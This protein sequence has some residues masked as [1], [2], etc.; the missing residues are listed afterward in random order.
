MIDLFSAPFKNVRKPYSSYLA[1]RARCYTMQTIMYVPTLGL[2]GKATHSAS[3]GYLAL[4]IFKPIFFVASITKIKA[5]R[6][7]YILMVEFSLSLHSAGMS[8]QGAPIASKSTLYKLRSSM[9][10]P[11]TSP[12]F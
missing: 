5:L 1:Y 10:F 9:P 7:Q 3:Y 6:K 11:K 2:T 4:V 8:R 12:L